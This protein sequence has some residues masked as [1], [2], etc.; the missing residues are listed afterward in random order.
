MTGYLTFA[1]KKKLLPYLVERDGYKCYLCGIE[2]K[3]IRE[4]IV[5]HL[6]DNPFH[7]DWDNLA[8]AHQRCN[9][10]KANDHKD[11]IDIAELKQE[12]NRIHI[13]VRENFSKKNHKVSTEIE[14]SNKCYPITEKYLVDSILE[15][16][17]LDYKSTLADIAYLCKAKTGHGS[18][19]Q[20]RNH[21]I[22]LTSSRAPFEIIKD[23]VTKKKI[24]RK[25]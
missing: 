15:Y 23:P 24:I 19:N 4:P 1:I 25:R 21:L 2:F 9:I 6:D 13:F 10:K 5:E 12:E 16:G 7:N 20:V 11:F 22:M 14:I 18:I 8:L 3:D 17:W